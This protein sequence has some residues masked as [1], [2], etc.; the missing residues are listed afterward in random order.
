MATKRTRRTRNQVA[1]VTPEAVGHFREAMARQDRYLACMTGE[2]RCIDER[3]RCAE[4]LEYLE[5]VRALK[6]ELRLRPWEPDPLTDDCPA[7]EELMRRSR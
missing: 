4:C 5:H 7:R 3:Q 2:I 6:R 1:G